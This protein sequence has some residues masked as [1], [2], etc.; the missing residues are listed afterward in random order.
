MLQKKVD[1]SRKKKKVKIFGSMDKS[2]F[3]CVF[4]RKIKEYLDVEANYC[5]CY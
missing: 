1:E 2:Y 3:R 5:S 4:G